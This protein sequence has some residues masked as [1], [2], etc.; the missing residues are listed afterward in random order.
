MKNTLIFLFA[1]FVL[2]SC[3]SKTNRGIHE[4]NMKC[5]STDSLFIKSVEITDDY[6]KINF[7]SISAGCKAYPPGHEKAMY[8]KDMAKDK[9][10]K[11]T[12]VEGIAIGP[13]FGK[14]TD[15]TLTFEPLPK[16]LFEFDIYEGTVDPQYA[17][18]F[19]NV[20][21]PEQGKE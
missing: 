3:N 5:S 13:D 19:N 7:N 16:D 15:F 18:T 10:Y 8:I 14:A 4:L 20:T 12:K 1:I 2:A 11:L 9:I 21:I 17:W 6:T